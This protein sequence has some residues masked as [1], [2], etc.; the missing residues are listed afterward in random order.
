MTGL[1]YR[2][3]ARLP[4][5]WLYGLSN[6]VAV[7]LQHVIRYRRQTVEDNLKQAFPMHL[8][9]GAGTSGELST[10]TFVIRLLRLLLGP[11]S[12]N[13]SSPTE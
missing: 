8:S 10:A 13:P 1:L 3:L 12:R 9:T 4:L 11:G 5:A 2:G 7:L 6:C